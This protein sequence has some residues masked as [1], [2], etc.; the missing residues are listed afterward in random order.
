MNRQVCK[1][2]T[3]ISLLAMLAVPI[4]QAQSDK[5]VANIP[6]DFHVG[7]A[8]LP[9]GEYTVRPM[10]PATLLI[11]SRDG[12]SSAVSLTIGVASAKIQ[13]TGKLVFN[14]YGELYFLSKVWGSGS[15]AGR[16]VLKSHSEIEMAKTISKPAVTVVAAKTP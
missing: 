8:S 10:N 2:L 11:Q 13:D 5:M 14:R 15:S 6:F 9:S 3:A 16:E 7:K 12:R 4:V 1:A